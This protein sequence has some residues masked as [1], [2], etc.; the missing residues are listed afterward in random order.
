MSIIFFDSSTL[1]SLAEAASLDILPALKDAFGGQLAITTTVKEETIDKAMVTD[2]FMYEGVRLRKMLDDGVLTLVGDGHVSE[3][4][5]KISNLVNNTFFVGKKPLKIIHAG[6]ISVLAVSLQ[7]NC[8]AVAIDERTMRLV[9]EDP[10]SLRQ[11]LESKLHT[12]ITVNKQNLLNWQDIIKGKVTVIR[13]TELAI[14]AWR[15]GLL[16]G[17]DEKALR[18]ILWALKFAGCAIS[19]DEINTYIKRLT[20]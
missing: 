3:L 18:G 16:A 7:Q 2:R 4:S 11:L 5:E 9:I 14:A 12:K 1:I 15:K 8:E 20:K 19:T 10:N 6:E 13:S 17:T